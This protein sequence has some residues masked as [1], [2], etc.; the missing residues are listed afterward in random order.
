MALG[1]QLISGQLKA[2]TK[3]YWAQL[4]SH[5]F[6]TPH[7]ECWFALLRHKITVTLLLLNLVYD[8]NHWILRWSDKPRNWFRLGT[9]EEKG[10]PIEITEAEMERTSLRQPPIYEAGFTLYLT[11]KSACLCLKHFLSSGVL[12]SHLCTKQ[13][14]GTESK[15]CLIYARHWPIF[16]WETE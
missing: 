8:T 3:P 9:Q 7:R 14:K 5:R 2:K 11:E 1:L 16:I 10:A 6:W 15:C 4:P 13:K 12:L